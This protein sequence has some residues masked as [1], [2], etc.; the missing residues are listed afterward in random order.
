MNLET[1]TGILLIWLM[2]IMILELNVPYIMLSAGIA[3]L[4]AYHATCLAYMHNLEDARDNAEREAQRMSHVAR[5]KQGNILECN[6][7]S[8]IQACAARSLKYIS[9][10]QQTNGTDFTIHTTHDKTGPVVMTVRET[11]T[12]QQ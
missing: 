7:R 10:V 2:T 1:A 12:T 5:L 9:L 6:P 3:M 4:T 11:P 8:S